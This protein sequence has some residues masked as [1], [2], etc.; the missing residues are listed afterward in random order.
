[1]GQERDGENGSI[2]GHTRIN[3]IGPLQNAAFEIDEVGEAVQRFKLVN[4]ARRA[5]AA[6][7]HENDRLVAVDAVG[8]MRHGRQRNQFAAEIALGVFVR[9][10]YVNELMF[11]ACITQGFQFLYGD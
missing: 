8:A 10:A 3:F 11:R 4:S 9:F 6:A 7:S 5:L 1:M 2:F